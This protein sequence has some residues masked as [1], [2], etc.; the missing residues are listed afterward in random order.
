M[1]FWKNDLVTERIYYC[2]ALGKFITF[3]LFHQVTSFN[4]FNYAYT[5]YK[6]WRKKDFSLTSCSILWNI[7]TGVEAVGNLWLLAA[8]LD[9][10]P[11]ILF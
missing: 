4:L 8:V 1:E 11:Q 6:K 9:F 10:H 7:G 5:Q 2:K 3:S